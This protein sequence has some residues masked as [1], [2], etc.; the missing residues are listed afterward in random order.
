M[1]CFKDC[2]CSWCFVF[3][4]FI[5]HFFP[6]FHL[7]LSL[8]TPLSLSLSLSPPL[9]LS[10]FPSLSLSLSLSL[11]TSLSLS[12]PSPFLLLSSSAQFVTIIIS[13]T[14][15]YSSDSKTTTQKAK[16]PSGREWACPRAEGRESDRSSPRNRVP[17][18]ET[19]T[20]VSSLQTRVTSTC[21]GVAP[22]LTRTT[23]SKPLSLK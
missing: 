19:P 5:I 6:P 17:K 1:F 4:F 2:L 13:K 12:L 7:Y 8:L 18:T 16:S 15:T 21:P 11:L 22:L 14:S 3:S 10:L 20:S 23:T 9:S